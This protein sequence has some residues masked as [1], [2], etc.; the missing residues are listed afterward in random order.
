MRFCRAVL[1]LL[2]LLAACTLSAPGGPRGILPAT[3]WD[4]RPEASEWTKATL[5]ALEAEG[6]VLVSS[7]PSDVGA[8]CP[9]YAAAPPARRKAFW[10]GLLSAV[11][12][13]ESR[14]NPGAAGGGGAY[15]G[16]M[17]I[18]DG[19]AAQN[20]CATG[21]A[22]YDGGENLAC[23]VRI[24]SGHVAR[25]G[26]IF[27]GTGQGWRGI[28]RDWIPFRRKEVRSDLAAWTAAQSY[29]R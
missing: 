1:P 19:T 15:K 23:A 29:C 17:Q 3:R 5:K 18:S 8:Y 7:V 16:L 4:H 22:L 25:D 14:W 11:A 21:A 10:V 28:A 27:G 20:G 26:A 9:G 13:V 2:A 24:V 6:A 12:G